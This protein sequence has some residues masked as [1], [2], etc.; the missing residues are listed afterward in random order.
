MKKLNFL[1]LCALI[2]FLFGCRT[3]DFADK[4]IESQQR[5]KITVLT[6]EQ[7]SK[8][9][10]LLQRISEYKKNIRSTNNLSKF[11]KTESNSILDDAIISTK[12]VVRIE[13][14]GNTTY[15]FPVFRTHL[16]E[17]IE[18]LVL[19]KN[20]NG[21]F[22]G[23]LMQYN[24]TKQEKDKYKR[25]EYVDVMKKLEVFPVDNIL[26]NIAA[27]TKSL[28]MGCVTIEYETGMCSQ[29]FHESGDVDVDEC[30]VGGP[31][32]IQIVSITVTCSSGDDNGG[33]G[34]TTGGNPYPSIE[35]G[36]GFTTFPFVSVGYEYF[37]T[38]DLRDPNYVLYNQV[39]NF[40]NSLGNSI[41]TLRNEN[42][43]LFYYAYFYFK[44][45]GLNTA[46]KTFISQR[47]TGLNNWYMNANST[48]WSINNQFFLNWAFWHLVVE[49]PD[50]SW[51]EFYNLFIATPC[52][53]LQHNSSD[54][55]FQGKLDSIKTRVLSTTPNRDMSETMVTVDKDK[56]VL[57]YNVSTVA[58]QGNGL[59]SVTGNT[60]NLS[61]AGMHNHPENSIPIFSYADIVT[62]YDTYK[63]LTPARQR[64][65]KDYLVSYNG[66]TYALQ[67]NDVSY[68]DTL[69]A[70]LNL[71]NSTTTEMD[72]K[73]AQEI[74]QKIY[75]RNKLKG[76]HAY[77]QTEAEQKFLKSISNPSMGMGNSIHIFRKDTD[78]W[79]KL[80]IDSN[81][82]ITKEN[83]P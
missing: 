69:F 55:K 28:S 74:V 46:T 5:L 1:M 49:D 18:N 72:K 53:T 40:F 26:I 47:L 17:K 38:E 54:I 71:G 15:T 8:E 16:S 9:P 21:S 25:G 27:R 24:T 51:E 81:G 68:L 19:K 52:E 42:P 48:N 76:D 23:V 35:P 7:L 44:D 82:N 12:R 30:T 45:N 50:E 3:E 41:N 62:F 33:D 39:G 10:Q 29:N 31:P 67:M 11:S 6:Q 13:N 80:N 77:T 66:T 65:Y 32:P 22:S 36:G 61:I 60:S 75:Y 78:G 37:A 57:T 34:G 56:G 4:D 2:L 14:N 63:F 20:E 79:G 58:S 64:V 73:K 70:G 59:I 43:D 83:C